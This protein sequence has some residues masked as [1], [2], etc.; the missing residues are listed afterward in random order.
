MPWAVSAWPIHLFIWLLGQQ[1]DPWNAINFVAGLYV[2]FY[3]FLLLL[4]LE[5]LGILIFAIHTQKQDFGGMFP[6]SESHRTVSLYVLTSRICQTTQS[7]NETSKC[8]S[9]FFFLFHNGKYILASA[10]TVSTA[11]KLPK[12]SL[13][14]FVSFQTMTHSLC[15]GSSFYNVTSSCW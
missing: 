6:T 11:P 10:I 13:Q 2:M 9:F 1:V 12:T 5:A 8:L 7:F 14:E 15:H 4:N 3:A